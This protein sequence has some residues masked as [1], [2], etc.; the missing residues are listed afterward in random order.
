MTFRRRSFGATA[1]CAYTTC[2]G[3]NKIIS[4]E[5]LPDRQ[6]KFIIFHAFS[7]LRQLT[8][9]EQCFFILLNK[10]LFA[11]SYPFKIEIFDR[12][13]KASCSECKCKN[14]CIAIIF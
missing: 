6:Q 9:F 4:F 12:E 14:I 8:L 5:R 13:Q 10:S 3:T 1:I 11:I 2:A 7:E